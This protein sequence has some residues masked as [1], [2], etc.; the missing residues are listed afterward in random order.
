[1][2]TVTKFIRLTTTVPGPRSKAIMDRKD[3][4][5][6]NAFSIHVPVAIKEASGALVTDVDQNT[7]RKS[8]V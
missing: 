8:V 3:A 4:L 5:V 2:S 6:P 7:F 1:M